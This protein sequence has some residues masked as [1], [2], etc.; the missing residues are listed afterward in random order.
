M[1]MVEREITGA[2]GPY[3]K[4]LAQG[5]LQLPRCRRC[6]AWHWPAVFRCGHCGAWDIDWA[7][8]RA[9]GEIYSWTRTHHGFAGTEGIGVPYVSVVVSLPHAGGRRLLGL[10]AGSDS[11]LRVGAWVRGRIATTRVGAVDVPALHWSMVDG[12]AG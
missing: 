7:P 1:T 8:V 3:W 10:L 6:R 9:E 11:G 2:D 4:G 5:Q 12:A